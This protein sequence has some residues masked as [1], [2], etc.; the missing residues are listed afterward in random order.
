MATVVYDQIRSDGRSEE[1]SAPD[2]EPGM[3]CGLGRH[4]LKPRA[5]LVNVELWPFCQA[6]KLGKEGPTVSR[7]D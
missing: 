6:S 2:Y 1:E 3:L 4:G 7:T 5:V